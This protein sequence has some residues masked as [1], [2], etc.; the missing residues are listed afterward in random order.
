MARFGQGFLQALTQPSYGQGLFELGSAI[1][2][3]PAAAKER[4]AKQ[5]AT[6][7]A[8]KAFNS[9]SP[10]EVLQAAQAV[11]QF[12]P[13]LAEQLRARAATLKQ[14]RAE[15]FQGVTV[16][17]AR[18][19]SADKKMIEKRLAERKKLEE[20][21]MGVIQRS[22]R[23]EEDKRRLMEGYLGADIKTL[24]DFLRTGGPSGSEIKSTRSGGQYRDTEGNIYEADI[25]RTPRGTNIN[26]VPI[27]PGAPQTPAGKLTPV[28]GQFRETAVEASARKAEEAGEEET[29]ETFAKLR[30]NAA[31]NIPELLAQQDL[32]NRAAD[33]LDN[34]D[35]TGV[36]AAIENEIRRLTGTQSPDAATYELAVGEAMYQRLKPLFGGV[37][38]EGERAAIEKLY[39]DLKRGNP[40][41]KAILK[42]LQ[43]QVNDSI[44]KSNLIRN[45]ENF[46]EYNTKLDKFFPSDSEASVSQPQVVGK[47]NAETGEVEFYGSNN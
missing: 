32:L 16:P 34:I 2:G 7:M 41:N 28:G 30:V 26:Y 12:D 11:Q 20:N 19:F 33:S 9:D 14:Q 45:S 43:K 46:K 5:A 8:N 22:D 23:P 6:A 4:Q 35:T 15:L 42:Q 1:G 36:P 38:S 29:A 13:K 44:T 3:A 25:Q 47:Y 24:T 18:D 17:K 21:V 39:N 40:A 31:E 10:S 27:T 37:I